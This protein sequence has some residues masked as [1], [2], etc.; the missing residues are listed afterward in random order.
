MAPLAVL[1]AL[2]LVAACATACGSSS[3]AAPTTTTEPAPAT[4]ADLAALV[5]PFEGTGSGPVAPGAVSTFPGADVPFGMVQWSPDTTPDRS[6]GSGYDYADSKISGFSLTHLSGA[7][8]PVFGDV[9]ILPTTG[10]IAPDP[11]GTTEPFSHV[12][13]SAAPGRY[14]VNLGTPTSPTSLTMVKLAATTR[15]GIGRFTFPATTA[16]NLLFKVSESA[17]G[18][19]ESSVK[20]VGSDEVTGSVTS[21]YFCSSLG[22]YTLHFVARF[23]RPFASH[24]VWESGKSHPGTSTCSG[25]F[26]A[27]CGGWV[28]FDA[29]TDRTVTMKVGVSYVSTANAADNLNAEDPGWSLGQVEARATQSWNDMLSRVVVRGG[30]HQQ[31][32]VFYTSLYHSLLDPSVFSD[33]NGQYM[34]FDGRV[35]DADGRAQYSNFS[36]WDIYRSEVPL[37]SMIAPDQ[38]SDMV[39]SL[40][41]DGA[42]GGWLPRWAVADSDSG[43]M[44]GDSAD[45]IIADAYAFGVR[46]FNVDEALKEMVKGATQVGTGPNFIQERQDLSQFNQSG[47]VPQNALEAVGVTVGGSETLEYA[48]DDFA[49][50]Q[51]A[52]GQG[53][54]ATYQKMMTQAQNWQAVFNPATG[55]VQARQANGSFLPGAAFPDTKAD[56]QS[57]GQSGFEEGNAIQYTWSVPQNLAGLFAAMGGNA[58]ATSKLNQF[59]TQLNASAFQPYD[60]AGNEPGLWTPWEYDYSGAPWR[61]QAVVRSIAD[62]LYT[63]QPAGEPGNDDLGALSSWYVW[64]ALGIYPLTPGTADL[65]VASPEFPSATIQLAGGKS[66]TLTAKGT[67]DVYVSAAS[68]S[69]GSA[70]ALPL[71]QPWLPAGLVHSGGT[72]SFTLGSVPD[73]SWG[74]SPQSAPPS[75]GDR[76][77]PAVGYTLPSGTV[78]AAPGTTMP[79]TLGLQSDVD[80]TTTVLWRASAHSGSVSPS[81]GRLVVP[82]V[83]AAGTYPR[84]STS[85]HV[86]APSAG[87]DEVQITFSVP[88]SKVRI[89]SLTLNVKAS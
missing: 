64:A 63:L 5:E 27:D 13:E 35:H 36:E 40:V 18:I 23:N 80:G 59:F 74:A 12:G 29:A 7:G 34:G 65:V 8:C 84:V 62:Q 2:A 55:Y 53:D 58:V 85:L 20:I 30:A 11:A 33:D 57:Q 46:G 81:S 24:G 60:W 14:Q 43:V 45:A 17:N 37:L 72:V 6:P 51:V 89:P 78:Q 26:Q 32:Q 77:A 83:S 38:V 42:Q 76:A 50:A 54:Q 44:N 31:Q 48:I 4:H 9:P 21:G 61:T 22:S 28:T 3:T 88:G 87:D 82:P 79:V 71:G 41:N 10:A 67:P 25:T 19:H 1:A 75:Y 73:T 39:Q 49:I 86:T 16:A 70:H 52:K 69:T 68:V 56:V 66:L 15:T 47:Y